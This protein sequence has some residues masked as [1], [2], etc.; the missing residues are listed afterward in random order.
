LLVKNC[1]SN[2]ISISKNTKEF[3]CEIIFSS[4]DVMFQEWISKKVIGE[5]LLNNGLYYLNQ[6]KFNLNT[7]KEDELSTL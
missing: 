4:K 5:G 2:L 7:R 1:A 6:E 3:K